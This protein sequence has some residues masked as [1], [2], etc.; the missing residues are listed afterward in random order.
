M[1]N[2]RAILDNYLASGYAGPS[3]EIVGVKRRGPKDPPNDSGGGRLQDS[4]RQF[5]YLRPTSVRKWWDGRKLEEKFSEFKTVIAD[6]NREPVGE[7]SSHDWQGDLP[8]DRCKGEARRSM[9]PSSKRECP[10]KLEFP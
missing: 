3:G 5:H 8:P 10:W 9:G 6:Y 2:R 1:P 4:E 7:T